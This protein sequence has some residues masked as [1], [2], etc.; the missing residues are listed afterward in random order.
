M[1]VHQKKVKGPTFILLMWLHV[2]PPAGVWFQGTEECDF[3][4]EM[5]RTHQLLKELDMGSYLW[6][7]NS[8]Q[9]KRGNLFSKWL[10]NVNN[11][12]VGGSSRELAL[13]KHLKSLS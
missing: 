2:A 3:F 8:S 11:G 6:E 9:A 7:G 1:L 5:F 13:G 4:S 10:C 12:P